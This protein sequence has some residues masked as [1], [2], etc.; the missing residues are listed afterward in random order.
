M[1]KLLFISTLLL[2]G[3]TSC[4]QKTDEGVMINGVVWATRNVGSSGR[5]VSQ[6]QDYGRR[7]TWEQAQNACPQGWRLP[8][9][10]ELQSL[11]LADNGWTT[12]TRNDNSGCPEFPSFTTVT[13][14]GRLFSSGGNSLFLPAPNRQGRY[15]SSISSN[16]PNAVLLQFDHDGSSIDIARTT[17]SFNVRCVAE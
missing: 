8:T 6:A 12:R 2:L 7:F 17:A 16:P 1:K 5:F 11:I 9:Q 14:G 15:W 3:F 10:I 4:Y 13:V